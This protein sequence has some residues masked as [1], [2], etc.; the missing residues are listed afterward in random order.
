MAGR[1]TLKIALSAVI[2]LGSGGFLLADTFKNTEA[3]EFYHPADA[4]IARASELQGQRIQMGGFVKDGTILNKKGTLE[5]Q[6]EVI[7]VEEE[8][9]HP[10]AKGR[11]VPVRYTGIVPDTFFE[12]NAQVIV[13]GEL[14]TDNVFHA[15]KLVAKCP[16]K[17]EASEKEDGTY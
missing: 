16:S 11:T 4:V 2:I 3:L 5:Y 7:P 14:K 9:K 13:S 6:F 12:P 8:M 15:T 10:E 17:Y 1:Q